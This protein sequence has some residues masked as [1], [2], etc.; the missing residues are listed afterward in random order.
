[1]AWF[2]LA[3]CLIGALLLAGRVLL[4]ADPKKLAKVIRITGGTL[5]GIAALALLAFGRPMLA[6][7]LGMGALLAFGR[8]PG[9]LGMGGGLFGVLGSLFGGA[10]QGRPGTGS[11]WPGAG[12]APGGGPRWHDAAGGAGN[13][14]QVQTAW[15]RMT[16]EHDTGEMSGTVLQGRF[17]GRRIEALQADELI[18]LLRE[19]EVEDP[20]SVSLLEAYLDRMVGPDWRRMHG[21]T[22]DRAGAGDRSEDGDRGRS[23]SRGGAQGGGADGGRRGRMSPA[24]AREILNVRT[25]AGPDEIREAHRRL[26]KKLHPDHG[27]SNYLAGKINEAKDVLLGT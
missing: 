11:A 24:E 15:L 2:I 10:G 13:S 9:G 6:G 17:R 18:V 25:D 7:L 21:G 20:D 1:M 8:A 22:G 3:L 4:T 26:M 27:G 23:G 12:G 14:S 5:L 19:C 16:L